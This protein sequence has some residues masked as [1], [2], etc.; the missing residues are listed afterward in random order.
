MACFCHAAVPCGA[1][2]ECGDDKE[3]D[4]YYVFNPVGFQVLTARDG[5]TKFTNDGLGCFE[6]GEWELE[7][8]ADGGGT[9]QSVEM[10]RA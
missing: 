7:E 2:E 10:Q 4:C 5:G 3:T 1:C 9:P 6:C 8:A